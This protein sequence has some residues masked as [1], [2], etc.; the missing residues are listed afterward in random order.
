MIIA[1][2][3]VIPR[4]E[5][6]LEY[7]SVAGVEKHLRRAAGILRGSA[8]L[9][10]L[11]HQAE[12]THAD[13]D[14]RYF[15]GTP[16]HLIENSRAEIPGNL[17]LPCSG[18]LV[19]VRITGLADIRERALFD[20]L[21]EHHTI[22]KSGLELVVELLF[23]DVGFRLAV[24][25]RE[26]GSRFIESLRLPGLLEGSQRLLAHFW[27][28]NGVGATILPHLVGDH[29]KPQLGF[30][31]LLTDRLKDAIGKHAYRSVHTLMRL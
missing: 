7:H 24:H 6:S 11:E 16:A 18:A 14:I 9:I 20:D 28:D 26:E 15:P 12:I 1:S 5:R 8:R 29:D 2:R 13:T 25:L 22:Q 4:A 19:E 3:I 23:V 30:L 17:R 31:R 10:L 27:L 21:G